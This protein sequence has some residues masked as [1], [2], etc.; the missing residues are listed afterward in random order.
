MGMHY[1]MLRFF[2]TEREIPTLLH[3]MG[4]EKGHTRR[5]YLKEIFSKDIR[6][7]GRTVPYSYVY[8]GETNSVILGRIG[9]IKAEVINDGPETGFA[10][11]TADFWHAANFLIDIDGSSDGQKIAFENSNDV[12][13]PI[14][15]MQYLVDYINN[16]NI[17]AKWHID[18]NT[19]T[20][21]KEFWSVVEA[22]KGRLTELDL[23]YVAPNIFGGTDETTKA[24]KK[25]NEKNNVQTTTVKLKNNE[26][27]LNPDSEDIHEGIDYIAKG[28]GK[29]KMKAGKDTI[30]DSEEKAVHKEV[31][32][33]NQFSI[34]EEAKTKWANLIKDI[35]NK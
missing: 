31:S 14:S 11:T 18:V 22:Y 3:A 5:E 17:D 2:L 35:F 4:V 19:I 16:K 9:R 20:E 7:L 10:D 32:K 26:G 24:L 34:L 1:S 23:T 15:I 8:I 21:T 27:A 12:G 6:F 13:A 28:R 33:E 29:V 30:Y 25:L